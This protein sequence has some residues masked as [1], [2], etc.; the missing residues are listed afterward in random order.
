MIK[1]KLYSLY[2]EDIRN[3]LATTLQEIATT[4]SGTLG[5]QGNTCVLFDEGHHNVPHVTKDGVTVAEFLQFDDRFQEVIN[6]LVKETA[7]KTGEKVGDGTTTS[8]MLACVLTGMLLTKYGDLE[9]LFPLIEK[10]IS[11]VIQNL[12]EAKVDLDI[13][14]KDTMHVLKSIINISCNNDKEIVDV[15]M[16]VIETIGPDGLIEVASSNNENT[17]VDIKEGMLIEA[18]AH[19]VTT[20]ELKEPA[21]VLVSSAI[22]KSHEIKSCL[23][24]SKQLKTGMGIGMIV[25]AK[26]FSKEVQAVVTK[27]NRLNITDVTLVEIDGF[28]LSMF[29]I[30]DD[31]ARLL[32]CKILSTDSSSEYGLQNVTFEMMSDKVDSAVV[33]PHNTVLKGK[34]FLNEDTLAIKEDLS[35]RIRT[36]KREGETKIGE[37]STLQKRLNKFSKSATIYV[38]GVTD[39]DK[40]EKRDRVDDAVKALEASIN[41]GVLP[42]SGSA[43]YHAKKDV[44]TDEIKLLTTA[45]VVAL[46]GEALFETFDKNLVKNLVTGEVGDAFTLG[47]LDPADVA[48]KALEQALAIAKLILKSHSI[49]VKWHDTQ[50]G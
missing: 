21:V 22:E 32:D 29:D 48:I 40:S 35:D 24:L 49:I 5:P 4:V 50:V 12:K 8:I 20:K 37:I 7:R 39:A 17:H 28:A 45:S 46:G 16:D 26:E 2:D 30:L 9:K 47:I 6:K 10:D 38:G 33:T 13:F 15:I 25:V 34:E 3:L 41:G 36:L 14:D 23:S 43:L 42:G 31:M 1:T 11:Q 27:N 18:P 44:E 19:V